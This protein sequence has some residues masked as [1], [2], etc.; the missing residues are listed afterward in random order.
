MIE[1]YRDFSVIIEH[2]LHCSIGII[3]N[4]LNRIQYEYFQYLVK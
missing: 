3:K 1:Y 2:K 4:Q